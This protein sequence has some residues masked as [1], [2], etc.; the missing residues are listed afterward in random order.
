METYFSENRK[1]KEDEEGKPLVAREGETTIVSEG[2][3]QVT[4]S[5]VQWRRLLRTLTTFDIFARDSPQVRSP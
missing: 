5:M 1:T 4:R 3:T 2:E